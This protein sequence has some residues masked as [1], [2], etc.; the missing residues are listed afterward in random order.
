MFAKV[1]TGKHLSSELKVNKGLRQG[2]A[3]DVVVMGR[4]LQAVEVFYGTG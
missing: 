1:K 4:R 3:D 2:D